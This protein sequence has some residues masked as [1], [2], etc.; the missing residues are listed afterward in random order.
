MKAHASP[1]TRFTPPPSD[2]ALQRQCGCG[3]HPAAVGGC[4]SCRQ[5]RPTVQRAALGP[6]PANAVPPIVHEVLRSP[7]QPLAGRTRALMEPRFGHDFSRVRVHTDAK[8][9]ES[10]RAVN[11]LAYTRGPDVVF[12]AEQYRPGTDEGR[13]L[14]AH[15]LTH[16]VQQDGQP[17]V[18]SPA[19]VTGP[20]DSPSE[21]EADRIVDT[22]GRDLGLRESTS[23]QAHPGYSSVPAIQSKTSSMIQRAVRFSPNNPLTIDHWTAGATTIAADEA[24]VV[25]GD[26]EA[27]AD[28]HAE[29][30]TAAELAN[31]EVGFLQNA[32]VTWDRTYWT[33]ADADGRGRFLE[34]K[35][36]VPA[37][38]LR[39]HLT[40]AI[41]W[42]APGEFAD[43]ASRAGGGTSADI[44]LT[45]TDAPN[46]PLDTHGS[47]VDGADASDGTDNI[48]Q[49][50]E[51]WNFV[52]FV[53]AHNTSTDEWRHLELI[54]W[55]AQTSVDFAPDPGGGVRLTRDDRALGQSRRFRWTTGADQPAIGATRANE[56]VNDPAQ[57]T[58]RRVAGWT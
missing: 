39:D 44:G 54:Y 58:T 1:P 21:R 28:I 24:T 9:A 5:R 26:F 7:G 6:S 23:A 50:R 55:S 36:R 27:T 18:P 33:R 46:T 29:A 47:S 15:E 43:V 42:A 3:N 20:V 49:H 17:S 16:V 30:D 48:F 11:A 32:Q 35:M 34:R 8:A 40:D 53:S 2:F 37:A 38:P 57:W 25:D 45:S 52:S 19:L 41:V 56:Y 51:R 12:A 4:E 31:W 10:A 22:V 14:M 13:R